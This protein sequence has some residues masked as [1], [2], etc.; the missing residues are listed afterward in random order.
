LAA[1]FAATDWIPINK[2]LWSFSFICLTSASACVAI[3]LLYYLVD[4]ARVWPN[5]QPFHYPGMNSILLYIGHE[6]TSQMLPWSFNVDETSHVGPLARNLVATTL[7]FVISVRLA[8]N[9][10]FLTV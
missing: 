1:L 3:S 6:L 7:W 9:N 4:V 2:N 10:F 5:G 8:Q